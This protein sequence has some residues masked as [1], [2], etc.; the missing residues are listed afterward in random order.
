MGSRVT[1]QAHTATPS[2]R[3]RASRALTGKRRDDPSLALREPSRRLFRDLPVEEWPPRRRWPVPGSRQPPTASSQVVE[4]APRPRACTASN[5]ST[6]GLPVAR[7]ACSGVRS[8]TCARVFANTPRASN[9]CGE[10]PSRTVGWKIFETYPHGKRYDRRHPRRC[11]GVAS[12][13]GFVVVE[14][15]DFGRASQRCLS[16]DRVHDSDLVHGGIIAQIVEPSEVMALAWA[17][18]RE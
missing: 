1:R 3:S 9:V 7:G 6:W 16:N 5:A 11:R 17:C 12:R 14:R 4:S 18:A 8:L 2:S 15:L 10:L 13:R